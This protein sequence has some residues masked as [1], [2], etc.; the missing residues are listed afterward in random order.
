MDL[1]QQREYYS[2]IHNVM[3]QETE[4]DLAMDILDRQVIA[5]SLLFCHNLCCQMMLDAVLS[6][7][8]FCLHL[9]VSLFDTTCSVTQISKDY[10]RETVA[11]FHTQVTDLSPS[12]T[13]ALLTTRHVTPDQPQPGERSKPFCTNFGADPRALVLAQSVISPRLLQLR[14]CLSPGHC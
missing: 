9:H 4:V 13:Q 14:G 8:K 7:P 11:L 12:T 5:L 6:S 10:A 1:L 2:H 3:L